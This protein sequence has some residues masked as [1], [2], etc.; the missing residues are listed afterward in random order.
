MV[1]LKVEDPADFQNFVRL[2]PAMFQ[3]LVDRLTPL[4]TKTDTNCCKALDPG[5]KLAIRFLATGESSKGLQYGFRLAYNTI[6]LL[7]PHVCQ[8]IVDDYHEEVIKTHTTPQDWMVVAKQMSRRRQYHHCLGAI[9]GKHV[10]IWKLMK[11]GSY[12]FNYQNFHSIVLMALLDGDY[13][14]IWVDVGSNGPSSDA[15]IFEDYELKHAIEQD[16]IGLPPADHLRDD[17]KD[18]PIFLLVMMPSRFGLI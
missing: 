16:V 17:D 6:C 7:I 2:E 10:A 13:K 4:I 11:A 9:D 14:F 15:Q 18:T 8:A 1:E 3:E 12:Y 5:L